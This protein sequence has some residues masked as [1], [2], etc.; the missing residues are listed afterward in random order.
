MSNN[1][2][3]VTCHYCRMPGELRPYGPNGAP[4]CFHCMKASPEREAA[5]SAMFGTQL[6]AAG[7]VAV[8]TKHGPVP[9][10]QHGRR[11]S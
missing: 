2:P 10:R 7:P 6:E 1:D 11:L 8:A 5:A 4:I 3:H 9:H